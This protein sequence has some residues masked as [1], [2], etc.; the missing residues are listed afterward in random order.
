MTKTLL[1]NGEG[2]DA[3]VVAS[4]VPADMPFDTAPNYGEPW[5]R[6]FDKVT[7]EVL[8]E[9]RLPAGVTGAPMSYMHRGKQYIVVAVGDRN[10]EPE[11]VALSLP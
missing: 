1:F 3:M 2:S 4:R 7:G 10:A 11:W 8:A 6:A 9:V 5:F